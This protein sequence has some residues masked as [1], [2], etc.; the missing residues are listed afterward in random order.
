MS[1]K[2]ERRQV[3]VKCGK[4]RTV[5]DPGELTNI[6]DIIARGRKTGMLVDPSKIGT[7]QARWGNFTTGGDFEEANFQIAKV[8][9]A[10]MELP[11]S[12]RAEFDNSP[13]KFLDA[14]VDP[15][16]EERFI[17]MGILPEKV[18]PDEAPVVAVETPVETPDE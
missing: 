7:R 18:I 3:V 12:L 6:N 11:S 5:Q 10:F 4:S 17:E 9:N 8:N 2:P 13:G 14:L 1:K 15:E 16:H